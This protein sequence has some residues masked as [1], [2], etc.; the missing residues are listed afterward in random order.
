MALPMEELPSIVQIIMHQSMEM[1]MM[2]FMM[3][4]QTLS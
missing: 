4:V 1:E 2:F 3:T